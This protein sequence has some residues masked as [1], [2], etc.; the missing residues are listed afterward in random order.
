MGLFTREKKESLDKGLD[1]TRESVFQKITRAVVGKSRIDDSLLDELEEILVTSDV[2]VETTLRIID[3]I[4]N[5][6]SRDKYMN[7]QELN[8]ILKEEILALLTENQAG[9]E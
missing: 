8:S 6:V 1:K 3:R 2:G 4:R 9:T 7:S 5:R